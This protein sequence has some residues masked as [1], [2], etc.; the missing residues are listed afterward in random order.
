MLGALPSPCKGS[1]R[2]REFSLEK[3]IHMARVSLKVRDTLRFD[4]SKGLEARW[5]GGLGGLAAPPLLLEEQERAAGDDAQAEQQDRVLAAHLGG[6]GGGARRRRRRGSG[7]RARGGGRR[8]GAPPART[9]AR[10]CHA[11]TR[12]GQHLRPHLVQATAGRGSEFAVDV[13]R[14]IAARLELRV[15]ESL[16]T[17]RFRGVLLPRHR[18]GRRVSTEAAHRTR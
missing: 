17:R 7:G 16:H 5:S 9:L 15:Q 1:W 12:S 8:W 10:G 11:L 2:K 18:R 6:G 14:T 3:S 4:S 13:D